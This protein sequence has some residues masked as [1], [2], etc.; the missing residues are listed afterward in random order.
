MPVLVTRLG[1]DGSLSTISA[2]RCSGGGG[3][4]E[5]DEAIVRLY[6]V[7][8]SSEQI[9]VVK[10][11]SRQGDARREYLRDGRMGPCTRRYKIKLG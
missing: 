4:E 6:K 8:K 5:E 1:C 3:F 10:S 7:G 9:G 2:A 11:P